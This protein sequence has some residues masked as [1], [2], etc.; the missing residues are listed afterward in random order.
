MP[1]N[2]VQNS[3]YKQF[4]ETSGEANL[5]LLYQIYWNWIIVL[6]HRNK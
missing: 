2:E 4:D 3:F 5:Y 1:Q 6:I